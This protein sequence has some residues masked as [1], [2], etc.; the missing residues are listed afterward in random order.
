MILKCINKEDKTHSEEYLQEI[1][2]V[3]EPTPLD[4]CSVVRWC[5]NCGAIVVDREVD[6]RIIGHFK[7]LTFPRRMS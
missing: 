7:E 5:S 3:T 1:M 2:R 4:E 6:N